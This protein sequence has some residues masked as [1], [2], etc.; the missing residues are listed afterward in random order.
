MCIRDSTYSMYDRL[1]FGGAVPATKEL[2]LETID[3]LK[4][5]FFLERRELGVINICLLY[6]SISLKCFPSLVV[7]SSIA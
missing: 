5:K 2:V 7:T 6:T 4:S 1:I 3:P